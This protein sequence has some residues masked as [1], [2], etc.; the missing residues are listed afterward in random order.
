MRDPQDDFFTD[1][2]EVLDKNQAIVSVNQSQKEPEPE[3]LFVT[4]R[5]T[6]EDYET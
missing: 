3:E 6:E 5:Q 2:P 1:E 4:P